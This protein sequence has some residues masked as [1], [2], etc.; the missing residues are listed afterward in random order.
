MDGIPRQNTEAWAKA[1]AGKITGSRFGDLTKD[2]T[3][4][5]WGVGAIS[6]A[7]ELVGE[8]LRLDDPDWRP[9][10]E[11]KT[12]PIEWGNN[13]EAFARA[14]YIFQTAYNVAEYGFMQHPKLKDVGASLDGVVVDQNGFIEIKCPFTTRE[15]V[16]T[17]HTKKVP[18]AYWGQVQGNLWVSGRDWCDFISFDPRIA[19]ELTLCIVRVER[20]ED[21]IQKLADKVKDFAVFVDYVESE[22]RNVAA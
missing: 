21:Y 22:V 15:H 3:G 11:L 16:R 7:Y 2:K 10:P 9:P 13:H 6:Y 17:I 1:R 20:D 18:K 5:N 19:E 4:K 8:R 14:A 12:A